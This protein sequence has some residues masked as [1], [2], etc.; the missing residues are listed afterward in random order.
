MVNPGWSLEKMVRAAL[1]SVGFETF[2]WRDWKKKRDSLGDEIL[3]QNSPLSHVIEVKGRTEFLVKSKRLGF[4]V[5]IECKNQSSPGSAWEK[6]PYAYYRLAK[7]A[8]EPLCLL[9]HGG[10]NPQHRMMCDWL[11]NNDELS[12]WIEGEER[13]ILILGIEEF[14]DWVYHSFRK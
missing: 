9:I 6:L 10:G 3:L 14:T 8:E 4:D 5:R 12:G 13:E 2:K 7:F 1:E 11:K